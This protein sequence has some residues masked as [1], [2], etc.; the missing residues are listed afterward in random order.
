MIYDH[1]YENLLDFP[2]FPP[3]EGKISDFATAYGRV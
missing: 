3:P 1:I 2:Y